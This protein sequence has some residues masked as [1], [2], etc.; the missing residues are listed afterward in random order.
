MLRAFFCAV[1][2]SLIILGAECLVVEKAVLAE[3]KQQVQQNSFMQFA[4]EV[5][6][7]AGRVVDPPEWAPWTMLSVGTVILLYAFTVSRE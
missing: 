5:P 3:T 4:A 6:S 2:I 1:G 7:Q